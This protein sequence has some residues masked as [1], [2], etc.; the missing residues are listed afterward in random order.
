MSSPI[1]LFERPFEAYS[2]RH[3]IMRATLM[4]NTDPIASGSTIIL[5]QYKLEDF[6]GYPVIRA[7]VHSDHVGYGSMYGWIQFVKC[8][9]NDEVPSHDREPTGVQDGCSDLD[10]QL[11]LAPIFQDSDIPFTYFG[12]DPT[13]FNAPTR[14][15]KTDFKWRAQTYLTYISDALITRQVT[16]I[17]GFAWGFNVEDGIKTI[18]PLEELDLNTSWNERLDALRRSYPSW[19]FNSAK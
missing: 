18:V 8:T 19:T 5:P 12:S 15:G 7:T 9:S 13:L 16:P 6:L 14:I 2:G 17:L 4:P 10:W 1:Q 3:G 11:D